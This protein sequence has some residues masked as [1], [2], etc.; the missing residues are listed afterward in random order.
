MRRNKHLL[1][2]SSL[3]TLALL[4]TAAGIEH[5]LQDWRRLQKTYARQLPDADRTQF[6]MQLRQ[7]VVPSL[8]ATDRC[9]SCHLGMAPG[10]KAIAGDRV[11]AAHSPLP[12]DPGEF[13][14]SVC[15]AGQN[16]ATETADAHGEVR[17][18]PEPMIPLEFSQAG[19]GGC[20]TH[21]A[22]P[23][24]DRLRRGMQLF[25]RYDCLACHSVD[26]RG[27]AVRPGWAAP[28]NTPDLS[29]AGSKGR[30]PD[31]YA[32][33][34]KRR[35]EEENPLWRSSFGEIPEGER[36]DIDVFLDSRVGA[37]KL[38][39]AKS[40]FH[41]KGC[42]G[43]HMVNG[44]G[45][46]DGPDLSVVGQK[47]P[48]LMNF[49]QVEGR[50][51]VANWMAEHLRA[52]ARVVTGSLMPTMGL[53]EAEV[54][55]LT[56][57]LLSLRRTA[58]P[59]AYWPLDRTR[60]TY[61]G[62]REF[63]D[64]GETL[65]RAFCSACHGPRGEGLRYPGASPFPA[66][67]NPDFLAVASDEF[68]AENIRRGRPGR[69]MPAWGEKAGGLR[70]E[71][72]EK[73]VAHVRSLGPPTEAAVLERPRRWANGD[74]DEGR[75]IY[76]TSCASCH[77]AKGEGV[78]GPALSNPVLLSAAS[79][80][81]LAETILRGRRGT[82]MPAFA[83]PATTHRVLSPREVESVVTFLRTWETDR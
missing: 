53:D 72:M 51:T 54:Q 64:D 55:T 14:C 7:I 13:G 56:L 1:L 15:H 10:E 35:A 77:G 4:L 30:N 22:V 78:E 28:A 26:G 20:H 36:A 25:E 50:P 19:C 52:P 42:R 45:G 58:A 24:W 61:L 33:H 6:S 59:Q 31:W 23:E 46:D 38:I 81:Y 62:A 48:A 12:H 17:F 65:Y 34:L 37:P 69:R 70:P 47:D 16:L 79:D 63:G 32:D 74:P 21:L 49:S 41:S 82:T 43:C 39:E 5:F 18:W 57:Y 9:V 60:A 11:F 73:I 3:G 44:V 8:N 40:M 66:I 68:L 80:A 75:S 67:G 29:N 27:G 76:E 71:E 2:W 83:Q